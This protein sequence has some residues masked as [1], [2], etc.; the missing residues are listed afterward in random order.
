[1]LTQFLEQLWAK[2]HVA[3]YAPLA[4]LD[5]ND[6]ALTVAIRNFQVG[7]LGA[8]H[9]GSVECHQQRAMEGSASRID[10]SR[11][12]FLAHDRGNV[13]G[14]FRIGGLGYAPAPLE[15]LGIEEPKSR[16]IY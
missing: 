10:E 12:F 6:H 11:H 4:T 9:S 5:V 2:H 14:P 1:M 8:S 13:L 15:S 3:I 16:K 7:Q